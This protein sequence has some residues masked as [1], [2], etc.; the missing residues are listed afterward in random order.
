M[1]IMDFMKILGNG[2]EDENRKTFGTLKKI[3]EIE[4]DIQVN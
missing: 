4:L 1:I 2:N 3:N